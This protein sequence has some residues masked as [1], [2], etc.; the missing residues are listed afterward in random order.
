MLGAMDLDFSEIVSWVFV[1]LLACF[2]KVEVCHYSTELWHLSCVAGAVLGPG[3][4]R[5]QSK[6]CCRPQGAGQPLS[7]AS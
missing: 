7:V 2:G 6:P 4:S 3:L 1:V 5:E